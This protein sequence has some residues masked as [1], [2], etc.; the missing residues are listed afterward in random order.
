MN[1]SKPRISLENER[2]DRPKGQPL[3]HSPRISLSTSISSKIGK[4]PKNQIEASTPVDVRARDRHVFRAAGLSESAFV[5]T[6][7]GEFA[8]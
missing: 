6:K 4:N 1:E 7:R 2:I 8:K 5:L 3:S